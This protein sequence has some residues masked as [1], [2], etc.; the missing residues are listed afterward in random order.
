M[1]GSVREKSAE[2]VIFV[3][4]LEQCDCAFLSVLSFFFLQ[5]SVCLDLV[6]LVHCVLV[7]FGHWFQSKDGRPFLSNK[8]GFLCCW[9]VD[10]FSLFYGRGN[11]HEEICKTCI[12]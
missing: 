10:P 7:S 11:R 9:T 12:K 1:K 2:G 5:V 8:V 6:Y 4:R 3:L